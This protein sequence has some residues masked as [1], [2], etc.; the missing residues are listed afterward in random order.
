[1]VVSAGKRLESLGVPPS[2]LLSCPAP[3]VTSHRTWASAVA[4]K[5]ML[6]RQDLKPIGVN[7][8]TAGPHARQTALAYR[9]AFG[10]ACRVGVIS[11]PTGDYRPDW[12]WA[13]SRGIHWVAKD[14]AGWLNLFL[15]GPRNDPEGG[16]TSPE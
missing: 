16:V 6:S 8:I 12:W 13:S 7:V 5:R 10:A 11:V 9:R 2:R 3:A 4:V 15:W 1:M 14:F